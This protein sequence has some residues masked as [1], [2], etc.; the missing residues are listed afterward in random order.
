MIGM[1]LVVL[2]VVIKLTTSASVLSFPQDDK[3]ICAFP[4][5]QQLHRHNFPLL[6]VFIAHQL[7]ARQNSG[8][9]LIRVHCNVLCLCA[10]LEG[11]IICIAGQCRR[12]HLPLS[13]Y[14]AL[15]GG[16][17]SS[18][19]HNQQQQQHRTSS[20]EQHIKNACWLLSS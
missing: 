10:L 15:G 17:V 13:S 2:V 18:G 11:Q 16:G 9:M 8:A 14:A 6:L 1:A 3:K 7:E 4:K 5:Q 19:C 12:R 20:N